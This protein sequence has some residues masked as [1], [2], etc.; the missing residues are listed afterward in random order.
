MRHGP[1]RTGALLFNAYI[2]ACLLVQIPPV[3]HNPQVEVTHCAARKIAQDLCAFYNIGQ[4]LVDIV[5]PVQDR[6]LPLYRSFLLDAH[7]P[8]MCGSVSS[9]SSYRPSEENLISTS[10][11]S[12]FSFVASRKRVLLARLSRYAG[13]FPASVW[14]W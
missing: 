5:V 10:G 14:R 12:S 7:V 2:L 8:T 11:R 3:V 1:L 9:R 13:W 4:G 6:F